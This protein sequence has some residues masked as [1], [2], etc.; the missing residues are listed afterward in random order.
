M[1]G[2]IASLGFPGRS[3]P[4]GKYNPLDSQYFYAKQLRIESIG[5]SPEF[6]DSRGFLKFN[7]KDNLKFIVDL[8]TSNTLNPK[9]L[10]AKEIQAGNLEAAYS[11]LLDKK[12]SPLTCILRWKK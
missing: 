7:E 9:A 6:P 1:R 2:T 3:E 4:P 12:L 8:I 11:E 10:T 5:Y